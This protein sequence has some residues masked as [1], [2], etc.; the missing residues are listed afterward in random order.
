MFVYLVRRLLEGFFVLILATTL[1]YLLLTLVP[2]GPL[3]EVQQP[4]VRIG[5]A[6]LNRLNQQMGLTNAQGQ[7]LP[8]YERYFYW[9]F[10]TERGGGIDIQIGDLQIQGSGIITGDLGQSTVVAPGRA[11]TELIGARLLNTVSLMGLALLI[12]AAISLLLG[13]ISAMKHYS[14]L[15]HI[16]TFFSFVGISLPTFWLAWI[17]IIIFGVKFK[18]WGLPYLPPSRAY[19]AGLEND[20]ADRLMHLILPVTVLSLTHIA[21][22]SRYLRSQMLET[23]RMDYIRTAWAK[24]LKKRTIIFKHAIRNAI[25]PLITVVTLSLPE[26]FGGAIIVES[27]FSYPGMGQLY[28]DSV[29]GYDWPVVMG[30]FLISASL[31]VVSNILADFL[32]ALVD[33][34]IRVA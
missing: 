4:G 22:W 25:L 10:S 29:R 30:I 34:R 1:V 18:E 9:L 32:Y 6:D 12:A 27:V 26:L 11:V 16:I 20:L 33:P 28:I 8:W 14:A 23:L 31:I 5:A 13:V 19:D 3:S 15:D 17:L 24:G 2:G 21:G 7:R